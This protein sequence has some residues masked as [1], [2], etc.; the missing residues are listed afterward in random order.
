MKRIHASRTLWAA[1]SLPVSGWLIQWWN[2]GM[3]PM[4]VQTFGP[5][6]VAVGVILLRL[7]TTTGVDFTPRK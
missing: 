2:G 4:H 7:A 6:A 3:L 1:A 5:L